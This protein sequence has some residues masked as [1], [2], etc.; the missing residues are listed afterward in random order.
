MIRK[1]FGI[2]T[3]GE[4]DNCIIFHE[5]GRINRSI[6]NVDFD[7]DDNHIFLN[8]P[9]V[10]FNGAIKTIS[11]ILDDNNIPRESYKFQ[12]RMGFDIFVKGGLE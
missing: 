7:L 10:Y 8:I 9:S 5:N 12:T 11:A 6:R 3:S 2:L 1:I 4:Y